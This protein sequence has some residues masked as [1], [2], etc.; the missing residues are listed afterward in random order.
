LTV[1]EAI[2]ILRDMKQD[3]TLKLEVVDNADHITI[4]TD[5]EGISSMTY[6]SDNV[7]DHCGES[8]SLPE[9]VLVWATYS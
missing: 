6:A 8:V 9:A 3:A 2:D 5:V 4:T 7:C 1:K